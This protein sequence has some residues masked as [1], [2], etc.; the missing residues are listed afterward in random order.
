MQKMGLYKA[1]ICKE[2]ANFHRYLQPKGLPEPEISPPT[3]IVTRSSFS[4]GTSWLA[5]FTLR[6]PCLTVR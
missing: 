4:E 1:H 2:D 5:W 6:L 3:V